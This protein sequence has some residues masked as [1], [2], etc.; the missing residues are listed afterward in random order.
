MSRAGF[1]FHSSVD[2][3][4]GG[5]IEILLLKDSQVLQNNRFEDSRREQL[6][7]VQSQR[8]RSSYYS[9]RLLTSGM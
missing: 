9:L 8:T 7:S 4:R 2:K 3:G 5:D 1:W 6:Q